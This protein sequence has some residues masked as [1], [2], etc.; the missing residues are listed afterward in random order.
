MASMAKPLLTDE[1]WNQIQH[2][3]PPPPPR[4]KGGRKRLDSR[5]VLTAI[6]FILRT[7]IPWHEFPLEMGCGSGMTAWRR[8]R[9]WQAQGVFQRLLQH[10][11]HELGEQGRLRAK[12]LMTDSSL[13]PAKRGA[14]IADPTLATEAN[15]VA[16]TTCVPT[17]RAFRSPRHSAPPTSL[18]VQ[19][20]PPW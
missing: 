2:L 14:R 9:D 8:L 6:L 15:Q 11:V 16:N 12:D 1:K 5:R 13:V 10:F 3:F 19:L 20:C 7:G 17:S 4:P 18:T